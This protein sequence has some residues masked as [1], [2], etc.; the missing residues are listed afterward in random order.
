MRMVASLVLCGVLCSA[1]VGAEGEDG[2]PV[3]EKQAPAIAQTRQKYY[4]LQK[5]FGAHQQK[6]AQDEELAALRKSAEEARRAYDSKLKEKMQD[7]P[8]I[9]GLLEQMEAVRAEMRQYFKTQRRR[10]DK[11]RPAPRKQAPAVLPEGAPAE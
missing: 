4:E 11:G 5:Q 9:A 7:D 8:E 10:P 3:E 2:Q 6:L 1:A